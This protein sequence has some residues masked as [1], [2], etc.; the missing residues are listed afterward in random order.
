MIS[1]T[2]II[3]LLYKHR[4]W[5]VKELVGPLGLFLSCMAVIGYLRGWLP[6]YLDRFLLLLMIPTMISICWI[7]LAAWRITDKLLKLEPELSE[8]LDS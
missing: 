3:R 4:S 1:T 8:F 6:E 2:E 5:T 7:G